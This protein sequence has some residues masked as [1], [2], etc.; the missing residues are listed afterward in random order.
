MENNVFF[1]RLYT[2]EQLP[3]K[4]IWICIWQLEIEIFI[5]N[6][7]YVL[8]TGPIHAVPFSQSVSYHR[9]FPQKLIQFFSSEMDLNAMKMILHADGSEP[10]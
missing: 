7:K 3:V 5:K 8:D 1:S 10:L 2:V 4:S 9:V 6:V